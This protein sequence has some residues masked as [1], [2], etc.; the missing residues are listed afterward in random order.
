[1]STKKIY[2]SPS[3]QYENKYFDGKHNEGE[4]CHTIS[5]ATEI[6]LK[7]SGVSV[8]R[9]KT[10]TYQQRAADSN[11]WGAD[12]HICIH[13]NAGG[14]DGT[15]VMC[16]SGNKNEKIV[17][18]IY[19]K[20]AAM[21]VG[22]DDGIKEVANLYEINNT[23]ALCVYLEIGFHDNSKEGEWI[24]EH[25]QEIGEAIAQAVCETYGYKYV[26]KSSENVSRETLYR[27]QVG[28][29]SEKAN[30]EKLEAE[31]KKKGY[32]TFIVKNS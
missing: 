9:G 30:A 21:S 8:K 14:G 17:K 4:V 1:M 15:L 28:A 19:N 22:K 27:V 2:L 13:T 16:H 31:L 7:R 32:D 11:K 18:N 5:G 24:I 10:G 26:P 23:N 6:A 12:V 3:D 20:I 25:E 29:F